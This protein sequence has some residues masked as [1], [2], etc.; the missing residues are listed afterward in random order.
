MLHHTRHNLGESEIM[1]FYDVIF[2]AQLQSDRIAF[3]VICINCLV[4]ISI[5][6]SKTAQ[7]M[8][9]SART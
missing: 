2:A 3:N 7:K 6:W 8:H 5:K 9:W 1:T 4:M